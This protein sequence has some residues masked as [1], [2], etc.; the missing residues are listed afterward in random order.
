MG[1]VVCVYVSDTD[2]VASSRSSEKV[3]DVA[4]ERARTSDEVEGRIGAGK[5]D[6]SEE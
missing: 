3:K 1:Y 5:E 4:S 2:R 6:H